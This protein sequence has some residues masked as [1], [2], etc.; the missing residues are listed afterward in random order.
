MKI[1]VVG[2]GYVG[3]SLATLL[4]QNDEVIIHDIDQNKVN[5]INKRISPVFDREITDF[6]KNKKLRLKATSSA[7]VGLKDAGFIIVCTP[8]NYDI[9]TSEFDVSKVES[10]IS[11][12]VKLKIEASIIIKS[13]VPVGFTE[14][15]KKKFKK[16]NIFF[17]PEFLREGS[18]LRDNLFPS[19]IIIGNDS[20]EARLFVELLLKNIDS[21]NHTIPIEYMNSTEAEAVKLFA[22]T[23]LA[24]RIAYFNELDSYCE[25]HDLDTGKVV[26]SIGHDPRIGNYYNNPSFGY[27]GYCLPKDTQQL[28][29][30]YDK[31]P[32]NLIKAVV[33][34]NTTRK[35]FIANSIIKKNP[36][37]V[38]IYRII[39]KEGSDNFR[40]S[41]IQ[42]VMK[43]IK[44]KGIKVI[45]YEP[46]MKDSTFFNSSVIND[47][48][49]FKSLS[50]LIIAN[51][52]SSEIMDVKEKVYTRDLFNRD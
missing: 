29:K 9:T 28:L 15:M 34:S 51:R 8:T 4:S 20:K 37:T 30:N 40:E 52:I 45:I 36:S 32:N 25:S 39:M 48:D 31:I 10:V 44:A 24:M 11:E 47:L 16:E 6:F 5:Q 3:I 2:A 50:S 7:H 13:T 42:G 49:K 41:A 38:G 19:R 21:I 17:S 27:G 1:T 26:T 22:N 14:N 35:D 46:L 43:R 23:Y 12:V 33:D 18:A